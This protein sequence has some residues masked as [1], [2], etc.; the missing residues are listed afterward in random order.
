MLDFPIFPIF[1]SLS[2][3]KVFHYRVQ[4]TGMNTNTEKWLLEGRILTNKLYFQV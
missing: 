4:R 3:F 2:I 1:S